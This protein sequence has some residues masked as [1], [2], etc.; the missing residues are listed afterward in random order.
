MSV[1]T[2]STLLPL[3]LL[4]GCVL[5][6]DDLDAWDR[7]HADDS[8][9]HLD[10][11]SDTDTDTDSDT[12]TDTD[13]D[14]DADT[15]TAVEPVELLEVQPSFG[16]RGGGSTVTLLG[17]GLTVAASVDFGGEAATL[18][19]QSDDGLVLSTPAVDAAG[20]VDVGVDQGGAAASLPEGFRYLDLD[21]ASGLSGA[22]GAL[23]WFDHVGSYWA[24]EIQD[25]GLVQL[26]FPAS[27][28]AGR[29]RDLFAEG[30]DRCASDRFAVDSSGGM[31]LSGANAVLSADLGSTLEP[32]WDAAELRFE[33]PVG[34]GELEDDSSFDLTL[35]GLWGLP[36]FTI[37]G[38]ASTPEP[39]R[40]TSPDM[41]GGSPIT[42]GNDELSFTWEAIEADAVVV[43]IAR[44]SNTGF[45]TLEVLT[46][47]AE[48]DGAFTIPSDAWAG[49]LPGNQLYTYVGALQESEATVPLNNGETSVAG[50]AWNVGVILAR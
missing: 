17:T 46:C 42:L 5:G 27:P 24:P 9:V 2:T 4:V 12:D 34:S 19:E 41:T 13:T 8:D 6:P 14:T 36:E 35:S 11:D 50:I 28:D 45:S 39:F 20:R 44:I 31:D 38:F 30:M 16:P 18:L 10:T 21:D 49:Y 48:N 1:A 25:Y 23:Q 15:D 22:L 40:L 32:V 7:A 29:Y 37:E 47:L 26:W 43:Y 3:A 33:L